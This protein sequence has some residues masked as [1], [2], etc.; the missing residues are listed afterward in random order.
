MNDNKRC[1]AIFLDL[2]KEFDTVN[3]KILLN[4]LDNVGVKG[5]ALN[6]F[7]DYLTGTIQRVKI[8]DLVSE[9]LPFTMGVP[10]GT[11]LGPILFLAFINNIPQLKNTKGHV[12]SYADVTVL[13]F[14]DNSWEVIYQYTELELQ[15]IHNWLNNSFLILNVSKTKCMTFST[16]AKDQPQKSFITMHK[17][18]CQQ[19]INCGCPNVRQTDS[20]KYL[21]VIC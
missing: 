19:N 4:R 3:H 17:S 1:L 5:S 12:I 11:V 7:Q 18:P 6:I 8:N 10:Q 15:I 2:A 13:I 20:I 14:V 16:Y 21:G 9:P